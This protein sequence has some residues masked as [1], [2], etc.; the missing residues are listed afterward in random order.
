MLYPNR[1]TYLIFLFCNNIDN[2]KVLGHLVKRK[3]S[4]GTARTVE[5]IEML[6]YKINPLYKDFTII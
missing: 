4:K 2:L 1:L 3:T 5:A 6:L